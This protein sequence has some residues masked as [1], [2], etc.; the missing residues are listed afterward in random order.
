[1]RTMA[2][3]LGVSS[4]L[5]SPTPA[6][7]PP[8]IINSGRLCSI[9]WSKTESRALLAVRPTNG[10]PL[11]H[12]LLPSYPSSHIGHHSDRLTRGEVNGIPSASTFLIRDI[13]RKHKHNLE[14]FLRIPVASPAGPADPAVPDAL[15]AA[16]NDRKSSQ[17]ICTQSIQSMLI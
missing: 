7:V 12:M 16:V 14:K 6:L 3:L 11:R 5:A 1:M 13:A 8:S 2:I 15:V 9:R 4:S 17:N 10:W